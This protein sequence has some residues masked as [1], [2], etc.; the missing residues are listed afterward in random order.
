PPGLM[1]HPR[2][3]WEAGAGGCQ[4]CAARGGDLRLAERHRFQLVGTRLRGR[5]AMDAS[6]GPALSPGDGSSRFLV[7]GR[8]RPNRDPEVRPNDPPPHRWAHS[9]DTRAV[10]ETAFLP[11]WEKLCQAQRTKRG[12]VVRY[13]APKRSSARPGES[14]TSSRVHRDRERVVPGTSSTAAAAMMVRPD[15]LEGGGGVVR[16]HRL[17]V[18]SGAKRQGASFW[19][20][21][22]RRKERNSRLA[23]TGRGSVRRL[24]LPVALGPAQGEDPAAAAV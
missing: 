7:F 23:S 6:A 5:R 1:I 18:C 19:A 8:I 11:S 3:G 10:G 21:G 16:G 9:H 15:L 12:A 4:T 20:T 17:L 14:G 24:R 13:R 2:R 22:R